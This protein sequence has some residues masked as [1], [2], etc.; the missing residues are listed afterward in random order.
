MPLPICPHCRHAMN[1]DDQVKNYVCYRCRSAKQDGEPGKTGVWAR[2]NVLQKPK[3]D[4][5]IERCWMTG[6]P[7]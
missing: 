6:F 3:I 1:F 2:L 7:A 5:V 4:R